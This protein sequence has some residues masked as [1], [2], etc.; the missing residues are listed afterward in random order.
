MFLFLTMQ[1][2][3]SCKMLFIMHFLINS[4]LIL[5]ASCN[6]QKV[7]ALTII[8]NIYYY[9]ISCSIHCNFWHFTGQFWQ[10][11]HQFKWKNDAILQQNVAATVKNCL[12]Q[13]GLF[14]ADIGITYMSDHLHNNGKIAESALDHVNHS[15]TMEKI[16]SCV[17]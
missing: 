17:W 15:E 16:I 4:L 8:E 11:R 5:H 13:C 14:N 2:F 10:Y 12:D 9:Y 3:I 6:H 1:S 7:L